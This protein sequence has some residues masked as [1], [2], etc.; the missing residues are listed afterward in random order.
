LLAKPFEGLVAFN[1][2]G[3]S[4]FWAREVETKTSGGVQYS[5]SPQTVISQIPPDGAYVVL[6]HF[7][8]GPGSSPEDYGPEHTSHDLGDLWAA[9]DCRDASGHRQA[10]FYK[11]GRLLRLEIY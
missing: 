9:Q 11:W 4:G 2:W 3:E 7:G 5:Y 6:I 10:D 8:G 1:S